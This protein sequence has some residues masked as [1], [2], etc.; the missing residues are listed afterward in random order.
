MKNR[1]HKYIIV[2]LL[3]TFT[4]GCLFSQCLNKEYLPEFFRNNSAERAIIYNFNIFYSLWLCIIGFVFSFIFFFIWRKRKTKENRSKVEG[5]KFF[6]IASLMWAISGSVSLF[7]DPI[8]DCCSFALFKSVFSSINSMFIIFALPSIE[9]ENNYLKRHLLHLR[10]NKVWVYILFSVI[11]GITFYLYNFCPDTLPGDVGVYHP[12]L[13]T[14]F[15]T[16]ILLSGV[17]SV[18]FFERKMKP[19][20]LLVLI[21]MILTSLAQIGLIFPDSNVFKIGEQRYYLI[22][23]EMVSS[24]IFKTSLMALLLILLYSWE[25]MNKEKSNKEASLV[26]V[27]NLAQSTNLFFSNSGEPLNNLKIEFSI[28]GK[29]HFNIENNTSLGPTSQLLKLSVYTKKRSYLIKV[30]QGN[31]EKQKIN[32]ID[33]KQVQRLRDIIPIFPKVLVNTQEN[34]TT[35]NIAPENIFFD[36]YNWDENKSEDNLCKEILD[37]YGV[38]E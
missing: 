21:C 33:S 16:I 17:L 29:V 24:T 5:I 28:H 18:A 38:K 36:G 34:K 27:D 35:I 7:I 32:E 2:I 6:S 4:G 12:D 9:I 14:S 13:I 22:T 1:A 19:M 8:V 23:F 30:P 25:I 10:R 3:I 15:I 37:F 31:V 11:L 26:S 20:L